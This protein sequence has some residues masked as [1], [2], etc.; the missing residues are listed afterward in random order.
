VHTPAPDELVDEVVVE[1]EVVLDVAL[2]PAPPVPEL[3]LLVVVAL[4]EVVVLDD[5]LPPVAPVPELLLVVLDAPPVP[6]VVPPPEPQPAA[7]IKAN[8][9]CAPRR[10]N[11]IVI[12]SSR[13]ARPSITRVAWDTRGA[14]GGAPSGDRGSINV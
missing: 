11:S 7:R 12:L 6:A 4:E 13:C 1:E 5:V 9:S 8:V 14:P 2:P 10:W 3:L